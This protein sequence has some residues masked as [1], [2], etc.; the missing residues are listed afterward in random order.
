MLLHIY[1][2]D[3]VMVPFQ[4]EVILQRLL[5]QEKKLRLQVSWAIDSV[6]HVWPVKDLHSIQCL[7]YL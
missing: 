7:I 2:T 3:R 5:P 4:L 6:G 1:L